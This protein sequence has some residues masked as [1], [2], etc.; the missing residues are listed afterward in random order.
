MRYS[1]F[2]A[3]GLVVLYL[4]KFRYNSE[5]R[6]SRELQT[7]VI[8]AE[9]EGFMDQSQKKSNPL[10]TFTRLMVGSAILGL[11]ELQRQLQAWEHAANHAYARET[12]T[13]S[14]ATTR[15]EA[16]SAPPVQSHTPGKVATVEQHTESPG[17]TMPQQPGPTDTPAKKLRYALIGLL[18]ESQ[19]RM[20]EGIATL[21]RVDQELGSMATSLT[22]PLQHSPLLAPARK[23]FGTYAARGETEVNRW[24]ERGRQEEAHSRILTETAGQLTF[25]SSVHQIAINSEVQELVQKQS[26]GLAGEVIE[27]VRERA[28]SADTLMERMARS[29]LRRT[30]REQLPEPPA[31]V[32]I[33]A[34]HIRSIEE[35]EA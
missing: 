14:P 25:E 33:R 23:R 2:G 11:D 8:V 34:E 24:I 7:Q 15:Q 18:F 35:L 20:E 12:Q 4:Q 26:T 27:E 19:S 9:I 28:V 16:R 29:L 32:R 6:H 30:P 3:Q 31:A 21:S 10:R 17:Q 13:R 1:L 5:S 22:R